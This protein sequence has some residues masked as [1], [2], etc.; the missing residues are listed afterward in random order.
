MTDA[1]GHTRQFDCI[2]CGR[3][4][5]QFGA[6]SPMKLCGACLMLPGWFRDSRLRAALDPDH[7]G[8]DPADEARNDR[9]RAD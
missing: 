9:R 4:I 7:D 3:H 5:M 6:A 2:E 8:V 1:D